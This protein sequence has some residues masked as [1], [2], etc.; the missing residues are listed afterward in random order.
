MVAAGEVIGSIS[1]E[2]QEGWFVWN[3]SLTLLLGYRKLSTSCAIRNHDLR[4]LQLERDY[5]RKVCCQG[6]TPVA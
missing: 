5:D 6:V 2:N 1:Q 4:P 3:Q